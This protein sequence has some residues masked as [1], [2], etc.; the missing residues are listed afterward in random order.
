[1]EG[2]DGRTTAT[3][4]PSLALLSNCRLPSVTH[5]SLSPVASV[6][7][8]FTG[9]LDATTNSGSDESPRQR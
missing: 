4:A 7:D 6:G 5:P 3:S 1:M 8:T 2:Q 9:S